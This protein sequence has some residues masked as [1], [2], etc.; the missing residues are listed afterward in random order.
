MS[1]IQGYSHFTNWIK[2]SYLRDLVHWEKTMYST[3]DAPNP[4]HI[5]C[6]SIPQGI[7]LELLLF[8]INLSEVYSSKQTSHADDARTSMSIQTPED[9]VTH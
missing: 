5:G 7:A 8:I 6:K 4:R 3:W 9:T 1:N 2:L